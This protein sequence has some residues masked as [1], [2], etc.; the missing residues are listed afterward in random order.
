VAHFAQLDEKNIVVQVIV[1]GD[2]FEESGETLFAEL[3]GGVWKR[4]SYNTFGNTHRTGGIPYRKNFAGIGMIY[5]EEKDAFY[6]PE[7]F[8]P[9]WVFDEESCTWNA[10]IPG[11]DDSKPYY[12]DEESRSWL[13]MESFGNEII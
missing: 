3:H 6:E 13:E 11:P 9:S 5:D 4:T 1:A 12:W 8:F 7:S 10:P 2:E